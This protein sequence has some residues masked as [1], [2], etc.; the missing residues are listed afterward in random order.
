MIQLISLIIDQFQSSLYF[1]NYL[2][3]IM[4]V[5]LLKFIN[6]NNLLYQYQFGFRKNHSTLLALTVLLD[7]ISDAFN[8][9]ELIVG[10]FLDFKKAFDTID[11]NILQQKLS[12][13]GI[14]G[15]S[16]S[17]ISSYL[18]N[19]K[20]CVTFNNFKNS[21]YLPITCGVPQGSILGPILFLLYVND[22][23]SVSSGAD[24]E[25]QLQ[26]GHKLDNLGKG[27]RPEAQCGRGSGGRFRPPEANGFQMV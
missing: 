18:S 3:R 5:R 11:H 22:L 19:R 13:Y 25:M 1:P 12:K 7:K 26:G 17:W 20:Q 16:L 10:I 15:V 8:N 2:K 23:P 21:K 24:P 9:S 4:Y 6:S 14:R 27:R